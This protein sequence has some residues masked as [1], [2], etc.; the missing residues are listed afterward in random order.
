MTPSSIAAAE[1][2]ADLAEFADQEGAAELLLGGAVEITGAAGANFWFYDPGEDCLVQVSDRFVL[3]GPSPLLR[4]VVQAAGP[5]TW[6]VPERNSA[7]NRPADGTDDL[8]GRFLGVPACDSGRSVFGILM[9]WRDLGQPGFT[10]VEARAL[11]EFLAAAAPYLRLHSRNPGRRRAGGA[12]RQGTGS[13]FRREAI[14]DYEAEL[15][16]RG[17]LLRVSEGFGWAAFLLLLLG[18]AALVVAALQV[19]VETSAAGPAVVRNTEKGWLAIG[20]LPGQIRP[21]LWP[22]QELQLALRGYPGV[23]WALPVG[24]LGKGMLSS[25]DLPADLGAALGAGNPSQ[26]PQ[27][28]IR[29]PL[30]DPDFTFAGRRYQLHDGMS[31]TI[32]V[33]LSEESLLDRLFPGL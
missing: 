4:S 20:T 21:R 18:F 2:L 28:L 17:R 26:E 19:K 1:Q 9:V 30:R 27:V 12:I 6:D 10:A 31:G 11:E 24:E 5:S 13:L 32:T 16:R 14:D 22:G 25:G 23:S 3:D 29:A 15:E 7:R 33:R 8:P